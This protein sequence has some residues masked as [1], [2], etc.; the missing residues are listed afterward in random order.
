MYYAIKISL[1]NLDKT[2]GGLQNST[3]ELLDLEGAYKPQT[4]IFQ[5]S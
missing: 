1:N 3:L 4:L 2:Y 5:V